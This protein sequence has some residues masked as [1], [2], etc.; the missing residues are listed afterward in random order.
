MP[1]AAERIRPLLPEMS[2]DEIVETLLDADYAAGRVT[3]EDLDLAHFQLLQ[4]T[5]RVRAANDTKET[6]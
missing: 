4:E 3:D 6:Q 2:D 5:A 1:S